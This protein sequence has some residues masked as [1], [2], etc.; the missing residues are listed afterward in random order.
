MFVACVSSSSSLSA[1]HAQQ[2]RS[3]CAVLMRKKLPAGDPMLFHKLDD[4]LCHA[5]KTE[6]LHAI[7]AEPETAVRKQIC[8]SVSELAIAVCSTENGW[9]EL[10]Q[11]LP[12]AA[13]SDS[14]MAGRMVGEERAPKGRIFVSSFIS[15][16]KN[17]H[18]ESGRGFDPHAV[19]IL[20]QPHSY[21]LRRIVLSFE[22]F[23]VAAVPMRES[24]LF[25]FGNI[26]TTSSAILEDKAPLVLQI[27]A[28][29]LSDPNINV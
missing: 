20:S 15:D 11:F 18:T 10:F 24:A 23:D 5:I 28:Q 21:L 1:P 27:C 26:A 8:D 2:V 16:Q 12:Q 4:A 3:W 19:Q 14:G 17:N 22:T 7:T 9:P 13:A 29:T 25:I 6:I